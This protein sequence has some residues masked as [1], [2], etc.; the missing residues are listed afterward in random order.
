M[1]H[2]PIIGVVVRQ[3]C[4]RGAESS[5]GGFPP[6]VARSA[7]SRTVPG[8]GH[9]SDAPRPR[10]DERARTLSSMPGTNTADVVTI[11][12]RKQAR[13]T[14]AH[15][16]ARRTGKV[17]LLE[18]GD[19]FFPRV[20]EVIATA[21]REILLQTFILFEDEVGNALHAALIAAAKRGVEVDVT[22]DGYGSYALSRDFVDALAAA[23][24]RLRVFDPCPQ[25]LGVRSRM[26]R[27]MHRKLLVVDGVRAFVGGINFAIDHVTDNGPRAKQDYAVELE[28][29][30]VA[31]IRAYIKATIADPRFSPGRRAGA[32]NA[33]RVR[34]VIRDNRRHRD[35][36]EVEYRR[37]I[38][39]ARREV[40]IANAYFFPG[41][42]LLRSLRTAAR[43]GVRVVL[44][45]QGLPDKAYTTFAARM[46]YHYLTAAGVRIYEYCERP[47]HGKVAVIDHGWATVG[48]SNLDPLSL[49][50]NLEANVVVRDARFTTQLRERL[51]ALIQRECRAVEPAKLPPRTP[52]RVFAGFIVFHVLRRFP[53]WAGLLPAHTPTV[54]LVEREGRSTAERR[55]RGPRWRW[56]TGGL[57]ALFLAVVSFLLYRQLRAVDWA[58]VSSTIAAYDRRALLLAVG[59]AAASYAAY[60]GYDVLARRYT[61]HA[62]ATRRIVGIAFVSYA[63]NLNFGTLIGGAGF[64]L[65]LYARSGLAAATIARILGFSITTNW[66]GYVALAG[67]ALTA[68]AVPIPVSWNIGT[69]GLQ[70]LGFILLAAVAGYVV[71]CAAFN[72]RTWIVRGHEIRLPSVRLALVQLAL[73]AANWLTIAALLFVLL[74]AHVAYH[75][76]LG[77]FLVSSIAGVL[78]HIPAGIGVIELVFLT[79]LGDKLPQHAIIAG[80][81]VYRAVYYLAPLL[82][83]VIVY[84]GLEASSRR[85]LRAQASKGLR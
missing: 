63:F 38:H 69:G 73:S 6:D 22:V 74:G 78:A 80:I 29:P 34:F 5:V 56:F 50:L 39:A 2:R 57:V 71:A 25:V 70:A 18:N 68:R 11:G 43:R 79:L 82:A 33:A 3:S 15:A 46:L 65:R 13:R 77:V 35:D 9:L 7:D 14:T 4:E 64:R 55:V 27:R 76:V 61:G 54:A 21:Q 28:G 47:F 23:G 36:I 85:Q 10:G 58:T 31:E 16:R 40:I 41:Y 44:L 12:R 17:R 67:G 84:A 45:L 66:V 24:V 49:S 42:L 32:T 48:S 8:S 1:A 26:F 53:K 30:A 20:L 59:L 19:E 81:V 75:L 52:L 72:E 60:C 37:A 51:L 83:A 62:L